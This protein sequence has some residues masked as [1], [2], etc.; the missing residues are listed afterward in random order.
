[1]TDAF[2]DLRIAT[3]SLRRFLYADAITETAMLPTS[4]IVLWSLGRQDRRLPLPSPISVPFGPDGVSWV[5]PRA[6]AVDLEGRSVDRIEA[7]GSLRFKSLTGSFALRIAFLAGFVLLT[8]PVQGAGPP[9]LLEGIRKLQIDVDR[10]AFIQTQVTRDRSG[11]IKDQRI[12]RVDPSLKFEVRRVLISVDGREPTDKE[13]R[14]FQKDREN[15]RLK[16]E[17]E[18]WKG[19]TINDKINLGEAVVLNESDQ[20]VVFE[21]PLV[22]NEE[23]R[24]PPERFQL[25]ITVD[26]EK[27]EIEEVSVRLREPLRAALVARLNRGEMTAR[28]SVADPVYTAPLTR[29]HAEGAGT[30]L[31]VRFGASHDEERTDFRR[32]TPWDERFSVEFGNL[33]FLGF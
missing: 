14:K 22:K 2:S 29:I 17:R 5:D 4:S 18:R 13:R 28:F 16:Q 31:F 6:H 11:A 23:Q 20:T 15:D 25:L 7:M 8:P 21:V 12:I 1:M 10:W 19:G 33:E 3:G 27:E 9:L 24:Y 30:V 32:V 26:R